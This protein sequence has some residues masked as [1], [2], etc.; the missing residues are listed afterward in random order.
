MKGDAML[1]TKKRPRYV[2]IHTSGP[3]YRC[4]AT[5]AA[6]LVTFGHARYVDQRGGTVIQIKERDNG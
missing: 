2:Q 6:M 1:D 4:A 3:V 5:E